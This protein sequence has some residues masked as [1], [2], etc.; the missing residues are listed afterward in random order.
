MTA[1]SSILL[2]VSD[3]S[4]IQY[5]GVYTAPANA[6]TVCVCVLSTVNCTTAGAG[7]PLT[8]NVEDWDQ[9][10]TNPNIL[11]SQDGL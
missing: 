10:H 9:N 3:V 11:P 7:A 8:I 2:N 4:T 5:S 1:T 6:G